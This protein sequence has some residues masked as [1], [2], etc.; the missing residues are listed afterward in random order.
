MT[1]VSPTGLGRIPRGQLETIQLIVAGAFASLAGSVTTIQFCFGLARFGGLEY[2]PRVSV[3]SSV[4]VLGPGTSVSATLIALLIWTHR[5]DAGAVQPTLSRAAPRAL[6]VAILSVAAT[7]ALAASFGFFVA[8]WVYDVPWDAI[9]KSRTVLSLSDIPAAVETFVGSAALASAFCWF[10]LPVMRR[11]SWSL[12]EKI[13]A[14]WAA[15]I[16]VR[17][18]FEFVN[19]TARHVRP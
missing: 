17:I 1:Q 13:G 12:A 16:L 2:A 19:L 5:L 11:R 9:A 8:H 14:T 7:T 10:A 18:I 6:L 15:A 4:R 3:M